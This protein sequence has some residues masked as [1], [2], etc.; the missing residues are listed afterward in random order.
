M[1]PG[2]MRQELSDVGTNPWAI[3]RLPSHKQ[4][5]S[6]GNSL[7][8]R[9]GFITFPQKFRKLYNHPSVSLL[10]FP[11]IF[12]ACNILNQCLPHQI[13]CHTSSY[14]SVLLNIGIFNFTAY[15]W[16]RAGRGSYF[17]LHLPIFSAKIFVLLKYKSIPRS[18]V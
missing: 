7:H 13:T 17:L 5:P 14:L 8:C 10:E 11:Q 2:M 12:R 18:L 16:A 4:P 9:A 6:F 15:P 3:M 1:I